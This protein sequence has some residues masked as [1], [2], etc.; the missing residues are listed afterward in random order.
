M[1]SP[2]DSERRHDR[3]D[4]IVANGRHATR[5]PD[6]QEDGPVGVEAPPSLPGRGARVQAGTLLFSVDGADAGVGMTTPDIS[7]R[8]VPDADLELARSAAGGNRPAFHALVDRH[9]K[10]LFRLAVS[11]SRNRSDAEDV[12]QETFVG[13]Y[14]GLSKFDGRS[15]VKT[16]LTQ[17]CIRQAAKQ[18]NRSKRAR[19]TVAIDGEGSA[20]AGGESLARASA[21]PDA[22][23]RMDLTAMIE[24]LPE[25][26]RQVIL[27][28]E[29]Q[30]L[31]YDEIARVLGVP[32][33]TVESRLHRARAGLKQRLR[34]YV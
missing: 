31:S 18:W 34:G 28:R 15:S 25:D 23:R 16:W 7:A 21:E 10:D 11:L 24:T 9:S 8:V 17:I 19:E 12:L 20:A 29:V 3:P 33:G 22:D 30:G 6:R 14:R 32:Q 5:P 27:M 1:T 26:H 4:A 2:G 13:A